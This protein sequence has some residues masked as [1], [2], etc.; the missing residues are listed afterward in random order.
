MEDCIIKPVSCCLQLAELGMFSVD[1]EFLF[2]I[3]DT[4]SQDTDL[5][6]AFSLARQGQ[7]RRQ[8]IMRRASHSFIIV[9]EADLEIL[10][11]CVRQ[12]VSS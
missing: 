7:Q 9:C 11:L 8:L 5:Q 4:S 6:Q 10:M 2:L 1:T 3:T 12:S